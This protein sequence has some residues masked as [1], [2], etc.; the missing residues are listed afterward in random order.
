MVSKQC[1]KCSKTVVYATPADMKRRS[2]TGMCRNCYLKNPMI[3]KEHGSWK[4]GIVKH[5]KGYTLIRK[6]NHPFCKGNGYIFEHRWVVEQHIG[7][8]LKVNE[9]IHHINGIKNDNRLENLV[10][11][12]NTEHCHKYDAHHPGVNRICDIPQCKKKHFG[13]GYC[14]QHYWT[15]Y[16]KSYRANK[17]AINH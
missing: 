15:E 9:I 17:K 3:G 2:K 5:E 16:L 4:G 12:N 6:P 10:I 11:T 13:R 8:Y 14:E 7:R 1:N